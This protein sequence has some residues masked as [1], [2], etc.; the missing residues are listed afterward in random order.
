MI[1][2]KL[3]LILQFPLIIY[4]Y[5]SLALLFA[6]Y[7]IAA[8]I[9]LIVFHFHHNHNHYHSNYHNHDVTFIEAKFFFMKVI[10]N[11]TIVNYFTFLLH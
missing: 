10:S 3:N 6:I 11:F 9:N 8:T 5:S 7:Y 4:M 1:I 2:L